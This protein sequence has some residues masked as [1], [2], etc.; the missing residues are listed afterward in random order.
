MTA[1]GFANLMRL[2]KSLY[3]EPAPDEPTHVK[4]ARIEEFS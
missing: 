1:D 3:L 2:S 4:I